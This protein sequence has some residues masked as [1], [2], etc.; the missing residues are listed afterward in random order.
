[1]KTG[2]FITFLLLFCFIAGPVNANT[3]KGD[4]VPPGLLM[5]TERGHTPPPGWQ[6]KSAMG[7][8]PDKNIH[9]Q[10]RVV[11]PVDHHGLVTVRLEGRLVKLYE[12]TRE[13][14]SVL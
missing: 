1:M 12:A 7:K 10:G 4:Q 11:I 3:N 13:V 5:K 6:K 2:Q 14:V 8:I 9:E